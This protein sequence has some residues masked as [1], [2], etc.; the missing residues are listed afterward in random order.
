VVSL[1]LALSAIPVS[2][3][4]A[5]NIP[6]YSLWDRFIKYDLRITDYDSLTDEEK[7]LCK[8]IFETER[9]APDTIVCER[10]RR[11]LAGYDVGERVDPEKIGNYYNIVD[12]CENYL[13]TTPY[14]DL[15]KDGY[16]IFLNEHSFIKD[17]AI[18]DTV[19][20][21][22]HLDDD[23]FYIEYWVDDDKTAS[24]EINNL[25]SYYTFDKDP[26]I[27]KVYDGDSYEV[28]EIEKNLAPL[29]TMEYEGCTYQIYPDNTLAFY[30]LD[31]KNVSSVD[32]PESIDGMEVTGIKMFA[33]DQCEITSVHLPETITYIEPFAFYQCE[34]LR[35]VNFPKGLKSIGGSGF[36]ECTAL[37]DLNI[38][39]PDLKFSSFSFYHCLA[40]NITVN[41]RVVPKNVTSHFFKYKSLNFGK[42]VTE[43]GY[44]LSLIHV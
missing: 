38:D 32:I 11:K 41:T 27:Y 3:V 13:L 20:D 29:P 9:S 44:N 43:I 6:D 19:P 5:E 17:M 12:R 14:T 33:F 1:I 8:F 28:Y 15:E 10:A 16:E 31:D 37:G 22:L 24:I 25:N 35:N 21:I 42:D 40:K 18:F 34:D 2:T 26:F 23:N 39:C 36:C 30:S 7:D 4:H